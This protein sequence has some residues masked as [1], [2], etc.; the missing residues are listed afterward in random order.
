M[1]V[2]VYVMRSA[3]GDRSTYQ[4][5]QGTVGRFRLRHKVLREGKVELHGAASECFREHLSA[6]PTIQ[7][8]ERRGQLAAI[9]RYMGREHEGFLRFLNRHRLRFERGSLSGEAM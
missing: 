1:H 3:W 7:V 4:C 2:C 9:E 6:F 8:D 5:G